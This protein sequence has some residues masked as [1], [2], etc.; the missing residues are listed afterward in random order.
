MA[1]PKLR[2]LTVLRSDLAPGVL[3]ALHENRRR[4]LPI[5]IFELDNIVELDPEA[6]TG[7][8]EERR[9]AFAELGRAA[10]YAG[11][12]SLL[13]ALLRELGF[14]ARFRAIEH[15]SFIAGRCAELDA[16]NGVTGVLGEIHP[17]VL[18]GLGLDHPAA[19]AEVTLHRIA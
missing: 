7:T 19:L 4:A 9:I 5:R 11:I 8:R 15:E 13:D 17:E 6:E 14:E 2:A 10:G 18:V 12:R 16:G 3:A 1:N